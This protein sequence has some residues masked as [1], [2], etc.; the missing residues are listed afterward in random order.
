MPPST[1]C[2]AG[3]SWG[4]FRLESEAR[5]PSIESK[6]V[7]DK[8][9]LHLCAAAELFSLAARK[10]QYVATVRLMHLTISGG[11]DRISRIHKLSTVDSEDPW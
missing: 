6:C 11:S 3:M 4:G 5:E 10:A 1:D 8:A 2:S 7:T 9:V